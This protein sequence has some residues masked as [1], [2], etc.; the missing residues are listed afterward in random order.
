[1]S[2]IILTQEMIQS[3][4]GEAYQPKA[5]PDCP[6]PQDILVGE[7][8]AAA[9]LIPFFYHKEQWHILFIRRTHSQNDRHSGQVAFPGGRCEQDDNS[10]LSTA[11]REAEEEVGIQA[12]DLVILGRMNDFITITNYR[13]SPFVGVFPFPYP[14]L[15]PQEGEVARIFS[16]PVDFLATPENLQ[17]RKRALPDGSHIPVYYFK[18]YDGE[19]LW[20]ASARITV[21][22][23]DILHLT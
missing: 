13:I 3:R 18:E 10:P 4:L 16:I 12:K 20:G 22:L 11:L 6:Y 9:I 2:N 1:M 5:E 15:R 23:L 21:S 19:T 7:P 14:S 8:Q 17:I